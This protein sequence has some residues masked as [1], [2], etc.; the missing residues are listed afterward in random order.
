M[1]EASDQQ[2]PGTVAPPQAARELA[3]MVREANT[4]E[5]AAELIEAYSR[6]VAIEAIGRYQER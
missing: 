6:T 1:S 4:I 5:T 2:R 3:Q